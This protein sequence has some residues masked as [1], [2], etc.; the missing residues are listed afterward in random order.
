MSQVFKNLRNLNAEAKMQTALKAYFANF[1]IQ[2]EQEKILS[3]IFRSI[4]KDNNG[5]ISKEEFRQ[6]YEIFGERTY[7]L[8]EEVDKLFELVDT[9]NN[10]VIDYSEFITSASN[11]NQLLSD[12]QLKA[13]FKALDLDGN[14]EI[15]YQEFEE[16]FAAGLNMEKA[17]LRSMFSEFDNN[18]NGMVN[19]EEFKTFLKQ[20]FHK[21]SQKEA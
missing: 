19:F 15:S 1:H 14:G 18:E 8:D 21:I 3:N 20:I 10:G 12:Q 4:D 16:T 11:M 9:N 13:A 6:A 17:E 5:T 7:L 2:D